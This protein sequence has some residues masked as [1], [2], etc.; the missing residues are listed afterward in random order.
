MDTI[1]RI[2]VDLAKNVIQIHAVDAAD[3]VVTRRAIARNRLLSWF[4]NLNPCL[5][6]M[7]ACSAAHYWARKLR[8]LGHEVRL[9]PPQFVAPYRKGGARVK[10]DA[11]DAEAICEAAG[12]PNMR[13]VPVKSP[14]QQSVL[15]LHRMRTG[16]VEER[17]ALIN[18]LR[19]LLAEFGLF[20][21]QRINQLHKYFVDSVE[22]ASNELAGPAREALMRA[23][24]KWHALDEE[25]A[26]FDRKIA[27]HANQDIEAKRCMEMCGIGPLTASATVAT[28]VDAHQ[29][30][31]G[32]QL[33]AWIGIVPKQNSSGGR[34][35]LGR[36]TKQGND[37]LRT[38]LVLGARSAIAAAARR[39][40]RLSRWI[41][42]LQA[43]IGYQ[44]TLV[45]IANKHARILWAILVKGEKFDPSHA[46]AR[47]RPTAGA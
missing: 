5:V 41:L 1:A 3:R 17:T 28:L 10:N 37:Y 6:A 2:G 9:I 40:D 11:R 33:A 43:R 12:R 45:A 27:E 39:D 22:D 36:I 23:W 21:P 7:E 30:R 47:P 38:L 8:A 42:Q 13:F 15:V 24:E 32:R 16:Y 19:G 18:R 29:F 34:Q 31:N 25:I 20:F 26:W 14:T 46:P 4:A 44:K 35:R